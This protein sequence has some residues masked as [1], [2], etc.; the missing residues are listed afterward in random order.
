MTAEDR[1]QIAC[2]QYLRLQYPDVLAFHTPNGGAR[3]AREGAKF[4]KM[5]VVPGV[6]DLLV[7]RYKEVE[8]MCLPDFIPGLAIELKIKPNRPTKAQKEMLAR[9]EAQGWVVAV[10]YDF[11]E[12]KKVVDDYLGN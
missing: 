1:L 10:C 2:W 12:F 7:V 6:P 9:F 3:N 5:G 11:D 4:K 8:R